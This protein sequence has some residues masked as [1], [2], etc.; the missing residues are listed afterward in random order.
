MSNSISVTV[1]SV[2]YGDRWHLLKQVADAVLQDEKVT[3]FV[4]VD[5]GCVDSKAMD[6]YA[7][8]H[9]NRIVILR[10]EKNIGYSGAISKGLEYA[11]STECNYVFV[12]DD[13]SVPELNAVDHF[14]DTLKLFPDNKV[15]LAGNRIY[16]PGNALVFHRKPIAS[17]K[18]KGTLFDVFNL[19]SLG[20]LV[21]IVLHRSRPANHP[22][23]PIVP[24]EAF[25][26]GGSFIPIEAVRKA[27]L[28]DS[29]LFIYGEDLEYSWRILRMGYTC[30]AV[31]RPIIRDID[32]TFQ[33][34]EGSHISGLFD[35]NTPDFKVYFRMRNAVIISRR[36]TTQWKII[37]ILNVIIWFIGLSLIGLLK[38]GPTPIYFRRIG[39]IARALLTG[40]FPKIPFPT[41]VKKPI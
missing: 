16:M 19:K 30:Y 5:N 2:V 39:L 40:F 27:S 13:D 22:F 6:Q 32:L 28:P 10:Q 3:K 33:P 11:Q 24:L 12:L 4:I 9:S 29:E 21:R 35:V 41:S 36:N 7:S 26:T 34:R 31:S 23:I 37:L 1:V 38:I 8:D 25:V 14:L 18:P 17:T 20:N 15:V